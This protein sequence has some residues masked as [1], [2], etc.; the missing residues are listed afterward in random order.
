[1]R[2][3]LVVLGLWFPLL[4]CTP[5]TP[6]ADRGTRAQ[7][8][9]EPRPATRVVTVGITTSVGSMGVLGTQGTTAGGFRSLSEVHSAGLVTS[10][11]HVQQPVPRLVTQR[12]S[13]SDGTISLLPDGQMRV[14]Y[15]L[16]GNVT[17]QDGVPFTAHDLVFTLD[18]LREPGLPLALGSSR[19][20]QLIESID[21][22]TDDRADFR[23]RAPY[24]LADALSLHDFWPQPRHL[25]HEPLQ[26]FR[27]T[28]NAEE[29]LRTPYWTAEYV[30]LGPFRL[31]SFQPDQELVFE[32]YPGFFLGPPKLDTIRVRVF[33]DQNPVFAALLAGAIDIVMSET[34]VADLGEQLRERWAS[35][36]AGTVYLN[37]GLTW[38]LNPQWRAGV[39]TEPATLD[40]RVRAAL[41]LALDRE[42]LA[43][44]LQGG[45]R[46]LALW[47]LVPP[48]HRYYAAARDGFQPYAYNPARARAVLSEA[49]WNVTTDGAAIH[50]GD[51][52]RFRTALWAPPRSD[53]A[54]AAMADYWRRLGL[55]VEEYSKTPAE[56]RDLQFR[57]L[58]PGWD[59]TARS[60]D[61]GILVLMEGPAASAANRWAGNRAGYEDPRAERLI[62]AY[63]T[64]IDERDQVQA[65]R[66]VSDFVSRELPFLALYSA[67]D[68]LAVRRGI[69][70]L[71]DTAGGR[72]YGTYSRNAHL[73]EVR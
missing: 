67:A 49:G 57:A 36:N 65:M 14:V 69:Q 12:P 46:E 62:D 15:Q 52:R 38:S 43:D 5:A 8:A 28:Q 55:E 18:L 42:A 47:S 34:L 58:Y 73:W 37:R 56:N 41:Y 68:H 11:L 50:G 72:G 16:R 61:D 44:A 21:A 51:G 10:D 7:P 45:H 6:L 19:V 26:R 64:S 63:R 4:A 33:A 2:W 17:W 25:L 29:F 71:E 70:A 9:A 54:V 59:L 30:H 48:E 53:N 3:L 1:M 60:G 23:F 32:A 24:Y 35:T 40:P 13:L 20:L 31:T 39:Q 27:A 22:P 66:A